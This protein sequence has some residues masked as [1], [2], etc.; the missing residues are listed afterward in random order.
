[1]G[2]GAG[3][4]TLQKN[5]VDGVIHVEDITTHAPVGIEINASHLRSAR[6][7]YVYGTAS[8]A[9]LGSK[10][11]VWNI[12]IKDEKEKLICVSRLTVALVNLNHTKQ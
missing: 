4:G 7:G 1:M 3:G 8:P 10:I 2:A 12:E 5:S 9:R 11:H 6:K